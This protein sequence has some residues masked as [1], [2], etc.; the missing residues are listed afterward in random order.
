MQIAK[1]KSSRQLV[2][3]K[4]IPIIVQVLYI[5]EWLTS[6]FVRPLEKYDPNFD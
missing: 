6:K 4:W 5:L 2:R 3:H 1:L